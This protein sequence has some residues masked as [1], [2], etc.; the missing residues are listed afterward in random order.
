MARNLL[1]TYIKE[2]VTLRK[3][4]PELKTKIIQ[5]VKEVGNVASVAKKYELPVTTVYGWMRRDSA[6]SSS[7]SNTSAREAG[8]S[9]VKQLEKKVADQEI[10][11][12]ILKELL[13][14]TNSAWLGK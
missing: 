7:I 9:K 11:I 1:K 4:S 6:K 13:K 12:Q 5:E 2:A 10:E 3:L 14:K 8:N